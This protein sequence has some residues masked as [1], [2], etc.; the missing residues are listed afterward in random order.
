MAVFNATMNMLAS[1]M[2]FANPQLDECI[3]FLKD[4]RDHELLFGAEVEKFITEVYRKALAL[5]IHLAE[6]SQAAEE[7]VKTAEWFGNQMGE[8]RKVFLKYLNFRKP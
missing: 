1:V 3:K 8:A 6:G 4:T 7:Q 2:K 5:H